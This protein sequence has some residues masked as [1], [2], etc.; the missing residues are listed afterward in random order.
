M[1]S[2]TMEVEL[3]TNKKTHKYFKIK[4]HIPRYSMGQEK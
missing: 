4:E 2:D 1:S 3:E